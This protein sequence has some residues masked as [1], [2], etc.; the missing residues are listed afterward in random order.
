MKKLK[1][2]KRVAHVALIV[3]ASLLSSA[4]SGVSAAVSK[5]ANSGK[6]SASGKTRSSKVDSVTLGDQQLQSAIETAEAMAQKAIDDKTVVGMAIAVV[7]NDKVVYRKGFGL[8]E[9]GN[10]A[11]VDADTVFQLA[12][13]SKPISSTVVAGL[14]GE[15]KITWDSKIS[16]LDPGF[17]LSEPWATREVTLRDFYAHRSGWPEHAGDLLEDIGYNREQV[18]HRMRYQEPESSFRSHYAYTNFGI[19][20]GA[21]AAS[22]A[23]GTTWEAASEERLYKPLK[24]NSTSSRYSDFIARS[25]KALGHVVVDGNWTHKTQ[26]QPDAQSPAGGVSSSVNDLAQWV[27]LQMG[28]GKVDGV[29]VID[30]AA[31]AETHK[32][33]MMTSYSPLNNLPGFYGL[34]MNVNYDE[35]ARLRLSHS[36]AF[37]MGAATNISMAPD[38]QIGIIVLTNCYPIGFA[39]AVASTFMDVA[40]DG[41]S[42]RDW[43]ALFKKVFADPKTLGLN[44]DARDYSKPPA[45]AVTALS[46]D[47]YVGTFTNKFF[48]DVAIATKDGALVL[49]LGP[50]KIEK[51]LKHYDRDVFSYETFGENASGLSAV[52][53]AVGADGKATSVEIE[54]LDIH[55][56]GLFTRKK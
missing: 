48:G 52:T 17:E 13:V 26:R 6:A 46:N 45:N 9:V 29:Q 2:K 28:K 20:E 40:L 43:V 56:Q 36:G 5:T 55:G 3:A 4:A 23:Y 21:V 27:R 54:A 39:E 8:R 51:V 37:A 33:H 38:Q 19:T 30:A 7:K 41:K 24:M 49:A 18:L 42:S 53:F 32:P 44:P 15:G 1:S 50:N 14:V 22:K 11:K 34:G 25:N 35:K 12:S 16:N 47:A 31:L 10:E